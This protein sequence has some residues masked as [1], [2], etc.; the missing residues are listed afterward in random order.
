MKE[1]SI[2]RSE[3]AV[4]VLLC[5]LVLS[6]FFVT[7]GEAESTR[8]RVIIQSDGAINPDTAPI[9]RDGDTYTFTGNISA[10][11][12]VQRSNVVIDGA[13]YTL[14]G[15]YNGTNESVFMIGQGPDQV[16]NDTKVPWSIGIDLA[17]PQITGLVV[18][19]LNIKNFSIGMYV[20]TENNLITGNTITESIVGILLSGS[21]NT[22]S[23][24]YVA[25]NTQGVFFGW[26]EAGEIPSTI[27]ISHNA[28]DANGQ[29]L[30][31]CVC[32][33]YNL[34]ETPH[35]WDDGEEGNYWSDYYGT[36]SDGD[37]IGDVPYVVD[38]LNQ[39]RYPLM[40]SPVSLPKVA[41]GFPLEIAIAAVLIV[42][43]AAAVAIVAKRKKIAGKTD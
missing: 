42:L 21:N 39:D 38:V 12:S 10:E 7:H 27:E 8:Q 3:L 11:I 40:Q 2:V 37:G 33:D 22:I 36:D 30:S 32:E 43:A 9:R 18:K 13:G 19:N 35:T 15:T 20:W 41:S 1:Q 16:S 5:V 17:F 29:H 14:H 28:F 24:N 6:V 26:D 34:T 31:G 25:K 23:G 4:A